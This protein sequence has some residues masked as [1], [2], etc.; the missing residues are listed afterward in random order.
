MKRL[1]I[2]YKSDD[3][4]VD[5]E[6]LECTYQPYREASTL[7]AGKTEGVSALVEFRVAGSAVEGDK[8]AESPENDNK[9]RADNEGLEAVEFTFVLLDIF[10]NFLD[11]LNALA[12]P[13]KFKETRKPHKSQW[14]FDIEGAPS[15]YHALCIPTQARFADG[16]VWR[17]DRKHCMEWINDVIG[18]SGLVLRLDEVFPDTGQ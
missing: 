12:G 2:S 18:E 5:V 4:P 10:D 6:R 9:I 16:G 17:I 1:I 3:C 8:G 7:Y 14:V 15:Q 11:T 13:G